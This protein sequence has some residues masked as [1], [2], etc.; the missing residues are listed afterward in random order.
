MN[1]KAVKKIS[2]LE[3]QRRD[4]KSAH[5]SKSLPVTFE[6][7][8]ADG[9]PVLVRHLPPV[10]N[11]PQKIAPP[12]GQMEINPVDV[13]KNSPIVAQPFFDTHKMKLNGAK[14]V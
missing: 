12:V 5:H 11:Q 10:K 14:N 8:D 4:F 9:F 1:T 6:K 2:A 13:A 3:N 7:P